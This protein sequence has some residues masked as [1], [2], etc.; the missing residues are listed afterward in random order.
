MLV[1]SVFRTITASFH[2]ICTFIRNSFK[3]QIIGGEVPLAFVVLTEDA[4]NRSAQ[5]QTV[6]NEITASIIKV[7]TQLYNMYFALSDRGRQHVADNKVAY[8]HLTG[9]VE[10]IPT[11]PTS[12]SGKLLRRVLRDQAKALRRPIAKL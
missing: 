7:T 1:S 12:P 5:N 6:L 9:G 8:K 4:R 10:F 2:T 11:I 3:Q